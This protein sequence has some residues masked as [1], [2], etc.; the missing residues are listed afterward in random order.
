MVNS[1]CT[2][3]MRDASGEV[4]EEV[5]AWQARRRNSRPGDVQVLVTHIL[6]LGT[7]SAR[8]THF[9]EQITAGS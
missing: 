1:S 3:A 8:V 2:V 7:C 6:S 5:I 9:A 4:N